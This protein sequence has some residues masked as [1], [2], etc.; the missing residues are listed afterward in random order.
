LGAAVEISVEEKGMKKAVF[1]HGA[2][3]Y[4]EKHGENL[5]WTSHNQ[6]EKRTQRRRDAKLSQSFFSFAFLCATL[7]ASRLCV[8]AFK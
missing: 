2:A 8:N 7:A 4:T 5:T 1:Q 3:E 6:K